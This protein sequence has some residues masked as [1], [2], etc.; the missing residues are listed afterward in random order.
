[1]PDARAFEGAQ[2][3]DVTEEREGLLTSKR[4]GQISITDKVCVRPYGR[5][6]HRLIGSSRHSSSFIGPLV[7]GLVAEL[8]GDIRYAFLFLVFMLWTALLVLVGV[9]V[10]RGRADA[11]IAN[12]SVLVDPSCALHREYGEQ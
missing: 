5:V 4:Y 8:T 11:P 7:V 2:N 10:E 12:R 6:N 9:D 1:L 3:V